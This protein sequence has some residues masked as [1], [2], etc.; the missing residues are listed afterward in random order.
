[1][2]KL[3]VGAQLVAEIAQDRSVE[4]V[5]KAIVSLAKVL[6]IETIAEGVETAGQLESLK[7]IGCHY[8]SGPYISSTM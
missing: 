8:A 6:N 2:Q 3:K 7:A 1:L 5:A 4:Q